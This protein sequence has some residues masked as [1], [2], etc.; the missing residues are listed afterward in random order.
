M[1]LASRQAGGDDQYDLLV[2]EEWCSLVLAARQQN[3]GRT[4]LKNGGG[5]ELVQ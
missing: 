5:L 1:G 4:I 3:L 2:W